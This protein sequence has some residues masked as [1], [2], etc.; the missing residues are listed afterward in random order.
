MPDGAEPCRRWSSSSPREGSEV[1]M[2]AGMGRAQRRA[3]VLG[4]LAVA[5]SWSVLFVGA[6]QPAAADT[7]SKQWYLSAM[8][9]ED[10]W[11]VTTGEGIKVAVVDTGVNS[12]TTSLQ[13]QVLKGVDVTGASGDETDDYDG[14][15]TTMAELIAGTGKGE[16]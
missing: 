13:G 9:A 16:T 2:T 5:A 10:M 8:Q 14:H 15:G 3:R 4:A 6:A 7:Q 12:S 11:K 1:G